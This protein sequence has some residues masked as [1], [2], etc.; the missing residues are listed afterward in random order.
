I[1]MP[2]KKYFRQHAHAN[3]Y[4]D[5]IEYPSSPENVNW[6]QLFKSENSN[7]DFLDLGCGY[8][9]FLIFLSGMFPDKNCVGMEIRK[10]VFLFV[11]E[12]IVALQGKQLMGKNCAIIQA[13]AMLFYINYFEKD[14]LE[15]IFCL[16]PDPHFKK[17][18]QKARIICKQMLDQMAYTLKP[19][20][21]IYIAT[22]VY[23]LYTNMVNVFEEHPLFYS[24]EPSTD[25]L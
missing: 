13:N 4:A 11:K 10:K 2:K 8:G 20:G 9:S 1:K 23:D 7:P 15:K 16:F 3:P 17:K 24:I 12:K 21:R 22:D 19:G 14:Q 18:K 25:I 5:Y 6:E